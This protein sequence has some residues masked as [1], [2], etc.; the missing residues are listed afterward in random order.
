MRKYIE[1]GITIIN[2]L[3]TVTQAF[4]FA[5]FSCQYMIPVS[6]FAFCYSRIFHTIRR[7]SKV[8]VSGHTGRR[9][10]IA[11]VTTSRDKNAGQLQ[12]Q[13]TGSTTG[14]KLSRIELNVIKL[15]LIHI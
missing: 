11:M 3:L 13:A 2:C 14:N 5:Q 15:S 6:V 8:F 7:Q 12:Q 10:N 1:D 4:P 9:Q